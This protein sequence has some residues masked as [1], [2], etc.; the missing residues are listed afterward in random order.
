MKLSIINKDKITQTKRKFSAEQEKQIIKLYKSEKSSLQLGKQFNC[1][2]R[3]IC[4]ILKRNRIKLKIQGS[5]PKYKINESFFKKIDSEEKAYF[6]GFFYADGCFVKDVPAIQISVKESDSEILQKL[7]NTANSNHPIYTSKNGNGRIAVFRIRNK[8]FFEHLKKFKINHY[9][10]KRLFFPEYIP[11]SLI[12]HFIRGYFDGDGSVYILKNKKIGASICGNKKF[13]TGLSKFLNKNNIRHSIN[14]QRTKNM[15]LWSVCMSGMYSAISFLNYL[16]KDST[17]Y[18]NRKFL[19][20]KLGILLCL[21]RKY[22]K[23]KLATGKK[24]IIDNHLIKK[25][26]IK[27]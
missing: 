2:D 11:N 1:W 12:R 7:L 15:F 21:N 14:K 27:F 13:I 10:T 9:K 23:E 25:Y 17:I 22:K 24:Y 26:E 5:E 4:N 8:C 3:T 19:K 20:F 6:L 18:M 16:Y